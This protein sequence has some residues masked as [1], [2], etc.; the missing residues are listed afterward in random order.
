MLHEHG[1]YVETPWA[2]DL[3][4]STTAP[5]A[6]FVKLANVPFLHAKPTYE[7]V[8]LV[9]PDED[10][11]LAVDLGGLEYDEICAQLMEDSRRWLMILHY[12]LVDPRGDAQSA[13]AALDRAAEQRDIV[14]EGGR[15]PTADGKPGSAYLAVPDEQTAQ[16][17]LDDLAGA[18]LPMRITLVHPVAEPAADAG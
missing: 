11:R 12:A 9:R 13:F 16:G 18:G 7:D 14:V 17:V 4:P 2:E 15:G 1:E 10:G 5:G 6:R 3:G 8:F